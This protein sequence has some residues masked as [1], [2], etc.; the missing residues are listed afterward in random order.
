VTTERRSTALPEVPTMAEAGVKEWFP[1]TWWAV[2]APKG[3]PAAIIRRLNSDVAQAM[4]GQDTI[5][6]FNALGLTAL[7]STPERVAEL[8][9]TGVVRMGQVVKAAGIQPE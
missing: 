4:K 1:Q 5:E 9:K 2:S 7:H 8:V 6:K 3:T